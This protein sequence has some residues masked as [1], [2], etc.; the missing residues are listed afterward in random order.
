MP[1]RMWIFLKK[2]LY[3]VNFQKQLILKQKEYSSLYN[4]YSWTTFLNKN[5]WKLDLLN[6][7]FCRSL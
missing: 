7:I 6:S 5:I 3:Y 4:S 2:Y 1:E